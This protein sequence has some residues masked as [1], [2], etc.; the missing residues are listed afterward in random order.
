RKA[1]FLSWVLCFGFLVLAHGVSATTNDNLLGNPG[2]KSALGSWV[3]SAGVVW[4]NKD[5]NG[6][7]SSGSAFVTDTFTNGDTPGLSQCVALPGSGPFDSGARFFF[8]SGQ[9]QAAFGYVFVFWYNVASCAGNTIGPEELVQTPVPVPT[10]SWTPITN[11]R[12]APPAGAVSALIAVGIGKSGSKTG[13]T[14]DGYIDGAFFRLTSCTPA[15][16]DLCLHGGRFRVTAQWESTTDGGDGHGV[17]FNND[18]G[19]FWFFDANNTEVVVKTVDACVDPFNHYW[20]FAAGLTNVLVTLNVEDT[21]AGA[22]N[23]YINPEGT[24]FLPLQDTSA[25]ATCP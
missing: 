10:D 25:F 5:A 23:R 18:S 1:H 20:V 11:L 7:V 3:A 13:P 2:F 14:V 8:P 9:G 16:Q 19:Y 22:V 15:D 12:L 21:V 6:S 24:A 17:Q 4:S